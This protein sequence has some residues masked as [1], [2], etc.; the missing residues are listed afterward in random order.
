MKNETKTA[1][2]VGFTMVVSVTIMI[3]IVA[4]L[5][6]WNL[7]SEGFIIKVQYNFLNDVLPGAPVKLAGGVKV[8][9]IIDIHQEGVKTIV[10]LFL[11]KNLKGQIPKSEKTQFA[12]F[13]TGFMGQKYIN[14]SVPPDPSSYKVFIKN[15]DLIRGVDPPSIDQIMLSFTSWFDGKNGGQVLA[16][17]VQETKAF[18]TGLNGLLKENRQDIR[19]TVKLAKVSFSKL[20]IQLDTLMVHLNKMSA[21]FQEIS[22]Q[23]KEDIKV[24][25]QNLSHISNDFSIISKRIQSGKGSVGKFIYGEE[26]YNNMNQA[27]KHAKVL[28]KKLKD[29]PHLL[30][31]RR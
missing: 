17:V 28:F 22:T 12:I 11:D 10:E 31:Y 24:M 1:T 14:L 6:K 2:I 8:G 15:G 29:K 20:S 7:G 16:E 25:L 13:T 26:I 9:Y 23:N 30:I 21:D 3:S 18:V 4:V 5:S 19:D 27:A